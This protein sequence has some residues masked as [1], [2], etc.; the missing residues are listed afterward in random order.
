MLQ[1]PPAFVAAESWPDCSEN[2]FF[3]PFPVTGCILV[4]Q[5]RDWLKFIHRGAFHAGSVRK[6]DASA[7]L[8]G[9]LL[10]INVVFFQWKYD[11][12]ANFNFS[13]KMQA[14]LLTFLYSFDARQPLKGN[15]AG[16]R[17][18][19][20]PLKR[21]ELFDR[22]ARLF[23]HQYVLYLTPYKPSLDGTNGNYIV[24]NR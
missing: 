14:F 9:K 22:R 15:L 4:L 6:S 24:L 1:Q 5:R 3:V 8:S 13:G 20:Q 19:A 21:E 23:I 18:Q 2:F 17:Q 12:S 7:G 10:E 11:K 16:A